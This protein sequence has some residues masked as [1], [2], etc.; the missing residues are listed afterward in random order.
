[1][2]IPAIAKFKVEKALGPSVVAKLL[3]TSTAAGAKS[4]PELANTMTINFDIP[5]DWEDISISNIYRG[6][7][8]CE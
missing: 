8:D 1:M 3:K 5:F 7:T 6:K 4:V 2:V